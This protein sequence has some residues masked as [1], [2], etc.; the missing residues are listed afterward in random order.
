MREVAIV[1]TG[2]ANL[3]SLEYAFERLSVR[4]RITQDP[5]VIREARHVVLPGVG[6]ASTAMKRLLNAR[7]LDALRTLTRP[8]LGICLG[9]Q[10]LFDASE[11][12]STECLGVIPGTV[13]R[14]KASPGRP[15]PHMGW[16]QLEG[17]CEDPLLMGI[18][19]RDY[20]YFVHSY[21]APVSDHTLARAE[22]GP[23]ISAVVRRGNFY[24]AQ[25]HP[26]RSGAP[27]AR[28]LQNFVRL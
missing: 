8:V 18:A 19:P 6:A 24:G 22:Y 11:E 5:V 26:E 14:L 4:A 13:Q 16:N 7:L 3:A 1:D 15:V 27:G 2:G 10:L 28:L 20:V 9:M 25:F 21:A 12:G 23:W 17:Q